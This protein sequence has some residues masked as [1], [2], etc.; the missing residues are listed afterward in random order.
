[1]TKLFLSYA[2]ADLP[3]I[4]ALID[5]LKAAGHSVWVDVHDEVG[6]G[7]WRRQIVAAIEGSEVVLLVLS[8]ASVASD[9]V[10]RELDIAVDAGK[11]I[12]PLGLD[13]VSI[14]DEMKYQ[15][16]G[17]ERV[18]F[19]ASF[20]QGAHALLKLLGTPA[21]GP[22]EPP[23]VPGPGA[24]L[25]AALKY[26]LLAGLVAAPL[27][28]WWNMV[29]TLG[30]CPEEQRVYLQALE[31][32]MALATQAYAS[33]G[34][35]EAYMAATRE[36]QAVFDVLPNKCKARW[37]EPNQAGRRVA[38]PQQWSAYEQCRTEQKKDLATGQLARACP[39][40]P[41]CPKF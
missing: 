1:M 5:R 24:R 18:D 26:G 7:Q 40:M 17:I 36:A 13:P 30:E 35:A 25:R 21:R 28:Y 34:D 41:A 11:R 38:C 27:S 29:T 12:V 39:S 2:R 31:T 3:R 9:N 4:Q 20:D 37:S 33:S 22:S 6:G 19:V 8:T 10:R 15:L 16:T 23:P 32:R 14:P